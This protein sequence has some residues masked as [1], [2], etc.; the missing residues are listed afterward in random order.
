LK[1]AL[2]RILIEEFPPEED[3]EHA[4]KEAKGFSKWAREEERRNNISSIKSVF[5][6]ERDD[7]HS[8]NDSN[9]DSIMADIE[10]VKVVKPADEVRE[11]G[12]TSYKEESM[13]DEKSELF[14][15]GSRRGGQHD[16]AIDI[17]DEEIISDF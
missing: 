6:G 17:D 16:T 3:I 12:E 10:K 9:E 4:V 15:D 14:G 1:S 13:M 11:G 5:I 7:Y 2:I 8:D